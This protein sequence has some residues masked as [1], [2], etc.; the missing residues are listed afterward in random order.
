MGPTRDPGGS[1]PLGI[2]DTDD[3]QVAFAL[4]RFLRRGVTMGLPARFVGEDGSGGDGAADKGGEGTSQD[5]G[6]HGGESPS[7]RRGPQG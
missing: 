4:D 6:S 3:E 5:K 7:R 1:C 2:R